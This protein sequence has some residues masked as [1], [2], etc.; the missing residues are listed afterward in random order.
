MMSK[1]Q[2]KYEKRVDDMI[3]DRTGM[4]LTPGNFGRECAGNGEHI[5]TE[6]VLIECCCDE[7]D[8]LLC[9]LKPENSCEHCNDRAC[10]RACQGNP[11]GI[12]GEKMDNYQRAFYELY[13]SVTKVLEELHHAQIKCFNISKGWDLKQQEKTEKKNLP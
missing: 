6:G 5:G 4:E 3:L 13:E 9:C 12:E 2:L 8:Y 1:K 11:E 7:C 10:P